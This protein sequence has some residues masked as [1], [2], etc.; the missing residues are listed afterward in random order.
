MADG[1]WRMADGQGW[2]QTVGAGAAEPNEV[3]YQVKQLVDLLIISTE[4]SV[5]LDQ[6]SKARPSMEIK[7]QQLAMKS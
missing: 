2:D 3:D 5:K 1:G 7:F 4:V 6:A